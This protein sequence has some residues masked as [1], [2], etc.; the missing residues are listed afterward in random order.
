GAQPAD[1]LLDDRD[2]AA[3]VRHATLD[4][5]GHELLELFRRVLEI[6][7]G[8]AVSLR[9]RADRAHA[10]IGLVR[11]ALVELDLAGRLLGAGEQAADHRRVRARHDCLRDI[12]RVTNAAVGN[13]RHAGP[14]E[15]FSD[16][17]HGRDLRYADAGDDTRRA[18]RARADADLDA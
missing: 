5:F 11:A 9:H 17:R 2:D 14:F 6:A 4:A 18:D 7:V 10:P 1:E 16:R 8:G 13:A 3:L 12:A 15:R